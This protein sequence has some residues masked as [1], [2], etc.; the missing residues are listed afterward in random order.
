MNKQQKKDKNKKVLTMVITFFPT[1]IIV[2]LS[3]LEVS[4]LRVILM[5]MV[6]FYQYMILNNLLDEYYGD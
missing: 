5:L 4:L 6:A 2:A 3:N 1:I